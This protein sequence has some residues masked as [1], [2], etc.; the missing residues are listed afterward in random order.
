MR[1]WAV[2]PAAGVGKRFS[3]DIPK[4]YLPLSGI[5]VLLHSINK[6]LKF[7]GLEEI[8]VVLNPAD[9]F[10][11]KLNFTHPKVKTIHGGL[12][13]CN[14]VNSAL[15]DLSGRAE[16]GD[17]VLVHDAVRPCI[18]DSDL[19]KITDI[20]HDEDVGGLLA[21]P[22]LDTI[23]EVDENLDVQKTIPREKLWSAMTPQIFRYELLKQAL[24][25]ALV[26]GGSVTDE[27]SAIESIGLTPRVV[28]GDKTNIKV[29]H[30]TDMVLAESIINTLLSK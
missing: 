28:Q 2:I 10:W 5:P 17:W 26:A 11:Q 29:T 24:E 23:K 4:Q 27:A 16:N 18:S 22:I 15:E 12:E 7:D 8:L 13:R 30:S 6:L 21:C 20:V 1:I 19:K 3:S 14:S 25:A 9:T